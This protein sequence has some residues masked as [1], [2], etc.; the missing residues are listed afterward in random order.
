[1][2]TEYLSFNSPN[3]IS[4]KMLNDSSIF[5]NFIGTWNY[6]STGN[7]MTTLKIT[8]NFNLRFLYNL[9]K[10]KVSQKIRDNMMKKLSLLKK[11]LIEVE[12]KN[13]LQQQ[14]K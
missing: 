4:I 14:L 8:Y 6:A 7:N 1:M 2:E 5:N 9:I 3:E 13:M 10:R 11:H 12:N